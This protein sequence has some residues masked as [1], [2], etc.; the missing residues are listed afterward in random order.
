MSP[1]RLTILL[2]VGLL[3][4]N[5]Y[6]AVSQSVAIDEAYTYNVFLAGPVDDLFTKYNANHH[7]LNSLFCKVSIGLLGLSEFSLRAVYSLRHGLSRSV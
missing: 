4:T 1:S 5:V 6:R 2:I 7:V 3:A